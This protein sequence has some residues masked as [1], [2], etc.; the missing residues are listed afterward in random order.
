[1]EYIGFK[2]IPLEKIKPYLTRSV[3]SSFVNNLAAK[4][5]THDYI[6]PVAVVPRESGFLCA[7]GVHRF[8]A[9]QKLKRQTAPCCIY[10][11]TDQELPILALLDNESLPMSRI[12]KAKVIQRMLDEGRKPEEVSDD[13]KIS[14][15]QLNNF[16]VL[17][18]IPEQYTHKIMEYPKRPNPDKPLTSTH[19]EEIEKLSIK[20]KEKRKSELYDLILKRARAARKD[21]D[22]K[23]YSH[24]DVRE[25][26]KKSNEQPSLSIKK[27]AEKFEAK[28]EKL[29]I[30]EEKKRKICPMCKGR[31]YL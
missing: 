6:A 4:I 21:S 12:D 7:G 14:M 26:V 20:K 5:A 27:V 16:L 15:V 9:L 29:T 30:S 31:G 22:I 23:I 17:L 10:K 3:D 1:M 11:A 8:L 13:L 25:I 28:K 24:R 2:H 18:N 19:V